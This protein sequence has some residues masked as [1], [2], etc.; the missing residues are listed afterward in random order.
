VKAQAV[1]VSC[2]GLERHGEGYPG[3]PQV[4]GKTAQL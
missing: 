3:R 1:L 4:C 2:A